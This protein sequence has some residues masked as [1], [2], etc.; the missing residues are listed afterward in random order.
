MYCA[1]SSVYRCVPSSAATALNNNFQFRLSQWSTL[2]TMLIEF[3]PW[4]HIAW[5]YVALIMAM[6][7]GPAYIDKWYVNSISNIYIIQRKEVYDLYKVQCT[8]CVDRWTP[9]ANKMNDTC[10]AYADMNERW[11]HKVI[12][13]IYKCIYGS[14][15]NSLMKQYSNKRAHRMRWNI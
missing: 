13:R 10:Y 15:C 4:I 2:I 14:Q 6:C 3:D 5:T 7:D 11:P 8:C 9:D 1:I 12:H